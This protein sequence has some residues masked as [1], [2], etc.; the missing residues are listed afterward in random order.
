MF[1]KNL[2]VFL[3]LGRK[4]IANMLIEDGANLNLVDVNNFTALEL[5][6]T[7]GN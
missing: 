1:P 5:A 2:H 3:N 7:N 6:E 4:E